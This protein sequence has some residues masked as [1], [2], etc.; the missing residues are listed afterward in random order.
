MGSYLIRGAQAVTMDD[1]LG[2]F[3][4]A[5]ILVR[6]GTIAAVAP[7]IEAGHHHGNDA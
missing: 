5:D 1:T 7:A 3:V 4:A 2:D 6:D